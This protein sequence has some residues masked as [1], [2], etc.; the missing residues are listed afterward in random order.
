M[1]EMLIDAIG[2]ADKGYWDDAH[3]IVQ[4]IEDPISYW[5]HANLHR[6]EGDIDN[7]KYWYHRALREYTEMEIEDERQQIRYL[8]EGDE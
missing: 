7:A 5:L 2:K 1:R 4:Q 3:M 8:L 6:E